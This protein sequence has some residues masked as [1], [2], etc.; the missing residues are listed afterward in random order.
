MI[1]KKYLEETNKKKYLELRIPKSRF[2]LLPKELEQT[3]KET[4][5]FQ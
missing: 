5:Q 4:K 3:H 2:K 1:P